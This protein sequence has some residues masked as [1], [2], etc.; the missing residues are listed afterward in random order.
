M[1]TT[2][3]PTLDDDLDLGRAKKWRNLWFLKNGESDWC[4]A[5]HDSEAAALALAK[6]NLA[7]CRKFPHE[8]VVW[9]SGKVLSGEVSHIIPMPVS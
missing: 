2:L 4:D 8:L 9:R 6:I 7:G 1:T 5:T 3:E